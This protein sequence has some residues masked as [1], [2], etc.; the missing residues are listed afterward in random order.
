MENLILNYKIV[1]AFWALAD[2]MEDDLKCRKYFIRLV[3]LR[4]NVGLLRDEMDKIQALAEQGNPFMQYAFARY[5][6]CLA[7]E[8]DSPAIAW[9]YYSKAIEAGIADARA[10]RAFFFRDGDLDEFDLMRYSK[11]MDI[12]REEGSEKAIEQQIRNLIFG[13]EGV[14]KDAELALSMASS[15]INKEKTDNE[16][17]NPM[18]LR[19]MGNAEI[20]L[21][22]YDKAREYFEQAVRYGDSGAYYQMAFHF[23]SNE[24][25]AIIDSE[26]F[27]EIMDK[28]NEVN[29]SEA[30]IQHIIQ[31]DFSSFDNLDEE[32]KERTSIAV[33][34]ELT[35][36]WL[37]GES[38]CPYF[39]GNLYSDG[40]LGFNQDYAQAW[41]WYS[42]GAALREPA[43]YV[44]MAELILDGLVTVEGADEEYGYYCQFKAYKLGED[45]MLM[46][47]C[48]AYEDG[49]LAR[50]A[51]IIET[52]CIP[53]RD[54]I[55]AIEEQEDE[56]ECEI[57]E[58]DWTSDP[59][60]DLRYHTCCEY[61]EMAERKTREQQYWNVSKTVNKYLDIAT[62]LL[63]FD[64]YVDELYAIND[65]FLDLIFYHPRLKLRLSRFQLNVLI[66]IEI[67]EDY[68]LGLIEDIQKDIDT[69]EKNIALADAGRQD[70]I[71]Q[72]GHLLRDPIEWTAKWENVIDE[73]ERKAYSRLKD[74]PRGMGFCF[75]YWAELRDA[76]M[77]FGI[78]WRTPQMMNPRV[79]FD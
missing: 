27:N 18:I 43:C 34:D 41:I 76:L 46:P 44:R 15:I 7:P 45:S 71:P 78:E 47:V 13:N 68:E 6:D 70:E 12:A 35:R 67:R 65:R 32:M 66:A 61:V 9:N 31:I 74:Y 59:D 29:A 36:G 24:D 57:G 55:M 33:K 52:E 26:G 69:L 22:R 58:D 62:Q 40:L 77:R 37:L 25:G 20:V 8:K 19:L 17:L 10:Y 4:N 72:A 53:K 38:I 23:C 28:A 56:Q 73:A 5:H 42:R 14:T 3:G 39:L 50:Y 60:I 2:K 51:D 11:E 64:M 1:E 75:S 79:M 63:E 30:S 21:G 54:E 48:E 49:H 16:L